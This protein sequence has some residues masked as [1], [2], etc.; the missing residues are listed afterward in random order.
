MLKS[1]LKQL[2][3]PRPVARVMQ[4]RSQSLHSLR[5]LHGRRAAL[6]LVDQLIVGVANFLTI[7]LLGRLAG[8]NDLGVF[9]LVMTVYYLL[10]SVQES[11]I[12]T[13]Y[14]IFGVRLKG[15]LRLQYS[16]AVLCQSAASASCIGVILALVA[17]SLF[18]SGQDAQ[19]VSVV[20]V[21]ALVAPLWL[22]REFGRRYLFA[23][24]QV[25]KVVAMSVVAGVAQL[26]VLFVLV[27]IGR[28]SASTALLAIG[29]GSGTAGFGWLW[30]SRGS[31]QFNRRRWSYFVHK[32]W[33][34]GRWL[35]ACQA[36]AVL[37][38]NTMPWLILIWLGPTATGLF[39]ACEALIRFANPI[40]VSL[41]NVLT[42]RLALGSNDGGKAEL[43][44]IV[45]KATALL[46]LFLF[47]FCIV[48]ALAGEWL[49]N[50]SFGKTYAGYWATLVVLGINQL[51]AKVALAPSRA[52]LLL[53]RVNINAFAE[54]ASFAV[55]L[56]LLPLLLPQY[57]TLGAALALLTGSLVYSVVI[58]WSYLAVMNEGERTPRFSIR[59]TTSP[60]APV[61][62]GL[63]VSQS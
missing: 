57:A 15:V 31:F 40:I 63:E 52:L 4:W 48:L 13:P 19:L 25:Q 18:L 42:P 9:A 22:L 26:I 2:S 58:I 56:L 43:N 39:A 37:S 60:T 44:R 7:L 11:L 41:N 47:A 59:R 54:G 20:G 17:L 1:A 53:Q 35:L 6:A 8:P 51:V 14:T 3:S 34:I 55:S 61:G 29:V 38:A 24:L 16:G 62:G 27:Y 36:T 45:C 21:F 10:L 23:H 33:S 12:T 30:L 49:L 46:T 32:N 5:G 28:L 50:Q